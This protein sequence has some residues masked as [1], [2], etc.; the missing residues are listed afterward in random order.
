MKSLENIFQM[1]KLYSIN[2]VQDFLAYCDE[3]GYCYEFLC[4]TKSVVLGDIMVYIY[5][6]TYKLIE[7][8][9]NCYQCKYRLQEY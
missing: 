2:E 3:H 8:C 5:N 9:V 4:D 6:K 1:E 7:V